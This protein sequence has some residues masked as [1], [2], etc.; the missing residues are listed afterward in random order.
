MPSG[1]Y[2]ERIREARPRLSKSFK[3]LADYILDSYIQ[4]ALMTTSELAHEVDVDAATVVR[5]AQALEYSGFPELQDEIRARVLESLLIHPQEVGQADS[6][7]AQVDQTLGQ[8][9]EAI[10][11]SRKLLDPDALE[12]LVG[13]LGASRRVLLLAD[14]AAR[15]AAQRMGAELEAVGVLSA[16]VPLEDAIIAQALANSQEQDALLAIDM[17]NKAPLIPLA[18][19]QAKSFGLQIAAIVGGASFEAAHQAG[20]VLEVQYQVESQAGDIVLTALVGAI[21]GAMRWQ[22]PARY[23]ENLAKLRKAQKR[24]TSAKPGVN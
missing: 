13:M 11:R 17:A 6:L 9:A 5:F 7:P 14:Q 3:R 24:L 1:T 12:S 15:L 2:S 8:L 21:G 22:H 16:W 4:A 10:E 20:I 19:T 18:L 23:G